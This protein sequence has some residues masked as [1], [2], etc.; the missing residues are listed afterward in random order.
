[1]YA[2]AQKPSRA[3]T[4]FT[5]FNF[6]VAAVM[7]ALGI[8]MLEATLSAKG[9]YAMAALMLVYSTAGITKALRD[10]EEA[11]RLHNRLED[12]RTER[13]LAEAVE[14]TPV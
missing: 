9:Y 12:A 3:W 4:A 14:E 13:M 6:G 10:R 5:Y 1:M 8:Y 2:Y 7:M 11:E